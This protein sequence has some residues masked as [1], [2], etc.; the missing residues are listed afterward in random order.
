MV[1]ERVLVEPIDALGERLRAGEFT[2]RALTEAYLDRLERVG[3]DLNAVVT[4]TRERAL[5]AADRLDGELDAG[6]DRGPLHGIPYGAKDLIAVEGYPTTW[7]A[8]SREGEH[9]EGTATVV[10]RLDAAGAVL[11][12]KLSTVELAGGLGYEQPD[13][14]FTGPGINP[15]NTGAW[16]GGSSCGPGSAAAAG[17]VG[18]AI[19]SETRGSI[20]SPAAYCG[21]AGLRPTYGAVSRHGAMALSWTMDKL[22]PLC[23][24]ARGAERVLSAIAGPDPEDPTTVDRPLDGGLPEEPVVAALDGAAEGTQEAVRA[25]YEASLSAVREF[26]EVETVEL[27]DYPYAEASD[28]IIA[29][30]ASAAFDGFVDAGEV[31]ELRA[32]ADRVGGYAQRTVLAKDYINAMRVRRKLQCD[33]DAAFAPYDA[34]V[35]PSRPTVA[36]PLDATF[37]EYRE[38]YE[39]TDLP[40]ATNLAGLPG[41]TVPNG[42]GERDLPTGISFTGRA[43]DDLVVAR[44]AAAFQERTDGVDYAELL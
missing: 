2:V 13:A 7:G 29:G 8:A 37:E 36:V 22:G 15:W 44:L 14:A 1:D 10:E 16:S 25:N 31:E 43:F 23:R 27:P 5:D 34:V 28:L 11:I 21:L 38:P 42:F 26:A 4:V 3:P 20:V 12:G 30:E 9:A 32:P 35:A 17:L 19:G 24:S 39:G 40:A 18:F 41:I 33:L 6:E